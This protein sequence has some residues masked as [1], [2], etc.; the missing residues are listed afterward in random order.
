VKLRE[1]SRK[2]EVTVSGRWYLALTVLVGVSAI[3]TG[4]NT[5]YIIES[6]L[7][8]GLILS[9]ILSEMT[10]AS[11]EVAI[12]RDA[13]VAGDPDRNGDTVIVRNLRKRHLFSLEI[14]EWIGGEYRPVAWIPE[15]RP[16]E[17]LV[18]P[19][20]RSYPARG[21]HRW[22]AIAI[23]T[24]HPF[25]L[26]RKFRFQTEG[27]T[28]LVWPSPL[29]GPGSTASSQEMRPRR[30]SPARHD[31]TDELRTLAPGD[32]IRLVVWTL[33]D[34]GTDPVV[35]S[36][37][38]RS[39]E[40]LVLLD[41]RC[42]ADGLFEISVS[43]AAASLLESDRSLVILDSEGRKVHQGSRASLDELARIRREAAP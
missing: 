11:I 16:R 42:A 7:L 31:E 15:L 18:V 43:R 26:A 39:P 13:A 32:D 6:L 22:D 19:S 12:R 8:S 34:K 36:R 30:P 4:N 27:G 21:L 33:S 38:N 3:T 1:Y 28:R 9:G 17:T 20:R 40:S 41:R 10:I 29:P 35:R 25:G 37:G 5:I 14:G 2:L 23:G 24:R